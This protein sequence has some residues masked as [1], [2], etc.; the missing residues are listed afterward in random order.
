MTRSPQ[1]RLRCLSH[2]SPLWRVQKKSHRCRIPQRMLECLSQEAYLRGW[3]A[4]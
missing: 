2:K 1:G 3:G 4:Y